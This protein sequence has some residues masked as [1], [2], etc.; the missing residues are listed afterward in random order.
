MIKGKPW[1]DDRYFNSLD[2]VA[3]KYLGEGKQPEQE[4]KEE[5]AHAP[6]EPTQPY[7]GV[8]VDDLPF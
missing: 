2:I 5:V 8:V 7:V 4:A 1:K 3:I 6:S